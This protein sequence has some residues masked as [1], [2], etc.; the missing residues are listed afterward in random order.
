MSDKL[1]TDGVKQFP[2]DL[3]L[4]VVVMERGVTPV[5]WGGCVAQTA[6]HLG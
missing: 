4:A 2:P 1:A 5:G 3:E 6:L